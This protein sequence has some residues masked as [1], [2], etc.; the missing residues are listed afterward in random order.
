MASIL[1]RGGL[2]LAMGMLGGGELGGDGV[3]KGVMEGKSRSGVGNKRRFKEQATELQSAGA[4]PCAGVGKSSA[5]LG[6]CQ[7]IASGERGVTKSCPSGPR[8]GEENSTGTLPKFKKRETAETGLTKS[9]EEKKG[10]QQKGMVDYL[11][12]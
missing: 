12:R 2:A 3:C 10:L 11:V 4:P 5:A 6:L 8:P 1:F 9:E 7:G